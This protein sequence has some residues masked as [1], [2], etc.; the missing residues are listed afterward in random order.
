M[1]EETAVAFIEWVYANPGKPATDYASE[2]AKV[3]L[4]LVAQENEACAQLAGGWAAATLSG[5]PR[6][7]ANGAQWVCLHLPLAIRNRT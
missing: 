2:L 5:Q 3:M 4:G 1:T 6:E 7:F